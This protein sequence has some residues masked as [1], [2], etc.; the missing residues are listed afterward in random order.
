[1]TIRVLVNGSEI[2]TPVKAFVVEDVSDDFTFQ[3]QIWLAPGD[4]R[5][6]AIVRTEGEGVAKAELTVIRRRE[7]SVK[8]DIENAP[9][10]YAVIVS[11]GN[12]QDARIPKLRFTRADAESFYQYLIDPDRGGFPSENVSGYSLS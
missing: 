7:P 3:R 6:E 10:Q 4:N 8:P 9:Q 12:Y 2:F 5:I 1:M 11:I